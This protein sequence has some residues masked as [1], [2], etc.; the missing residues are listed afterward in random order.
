MKG[1]RLC[2]AVTA[3]AVAG[4]AGQAQQNDTGL[5]RG[6]VVSQIL[7][8]DRDKFLLE[9]A[10]GKRIRR[11]A[12]TEVRKLA[13]ENRSIEADLKAEELDLTNRRSSMAPE[14]FRVL[15]DAFDLKVQQTRKT[16]DDKNRA[17]QQALDG[18][19]TALE[20]A[21]V[22]V[23]Q[24]LMRDAGAAVILERGSVFLSAQFIDITDEAIRRLDATLGDGSKP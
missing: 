11:E 1:L 12:D 10:F 23:L 13:A 18:E 6:G 20:N 3:L 21:A 17:L 8:I 15:A 2:A 24:K 5:Q 4:V 7:T 19:L 22:P 9:S 14:D 16:Q